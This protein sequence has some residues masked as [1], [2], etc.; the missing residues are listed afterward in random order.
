MY[1]RLD[2]GLPGKGPHS[3]AGSVVVRMP[4][5]GGAESRD[6]LHVPERRWQRL[7]R[8]ADLPV[9]RDRASRYP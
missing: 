7:Q 8:L 5:I 6:G 3:P 1:V 4:S 9:S 2:V